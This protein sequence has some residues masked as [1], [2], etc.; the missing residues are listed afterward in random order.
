MRSEDGLRV[1][2]GAPSAHSQS[3]GSDSEGWDRWGFWV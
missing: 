1:S 2:Q 3:G